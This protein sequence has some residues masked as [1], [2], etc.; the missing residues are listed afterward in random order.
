L[1]RL[2]DPSEIN[3]DNLNNFKCET[4]TH[5]RNKQREYLKDKIDELATNIRDLYREINGF[6][7]SYQPGSNLVKNENGDLLADSHNIRIGGRTTSLSY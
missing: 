5:F 7:R 2:Q 1:Q 4:S 3:A 6:K